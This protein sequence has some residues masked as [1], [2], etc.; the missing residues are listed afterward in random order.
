MEAEM[1]LITP[2]TPSLHWRQVFLFHDRIALIKP[3]RKT[4]F[5]QYAVLHLIYSFFPSNGKIRF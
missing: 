1:I 3:L 5:F 4:G 2:D